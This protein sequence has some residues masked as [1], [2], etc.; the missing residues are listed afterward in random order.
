MIEIERKFL[1]KDEIREVLKYLEP[2]SIRQGYLMD[3][4]GQ[5]V[6]VR[7]KGDKGFLTIKG[8]AEGISRAEFEYEIPLEEAVQLLDHFCKWELSKDRYAIQ[9][10]GK[11]WDVDVFHG[12]HEGLILAEIELEDENE[13]FEHPNW[14]L[15]EVSHNERYYN[16]NLV[17]E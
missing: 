1:V 10:A 7:T 2:K 6:R 9:V 11:T 4:N 8:K 17:K 12:R 3:E 15:E 5:T 16:S 14:L 13:V